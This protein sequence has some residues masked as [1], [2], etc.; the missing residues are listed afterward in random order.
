[1]KNCLIS[2]F[3]MLQIQLLTG[4]CPVFMDFHSQ[5]EIDNFASQYPN[6]TETTWNLTF[7][8]A[9]ITSLAP[10]AQLT[11]VAGGL[12]IS[13]TSLM[14]LEGLENI[15]FVENSIEII[16]NPYLTTLAALSNIAGEIGQPGGGL[17]INSNESLTSLTGLENISSID[18]GIN[19]AS[20]ASLG[21][22]TG[23]DGIAFVTDNLYI[24]GNSSLLNLGGLGALTSVY[25]IYIQGNSAM[26][27]MNGIGIVTAIPGSLTIY[28]NPNL[29]DLNDLTSLASVGNNLNLNGNTSLSSLGGLSSLSQ[30]GG[31]LNI[32][33]SALT[34]LSGLEELTSVGGGISISGNDTLT[35]ISGLSGLSNVGDVINIS[36]NPQLSECKTADLCQF[37]VAFWSNACGCSSF[38]EVCGGGGAQLI[39]F[40]IVEQE[41]N[42]FLLQDTINL[43]EPPGQDNSYGVLGRVATDGNINIIDISGYFVASGLR[44]AGDPGDVDLNGYLYKYSDQNNWEQYYYF[45]PRIFSNSGTTETVTLEV[46]DY[47]CPDKVY[48]TFEIEKHRTPVLLI[49]GLYSEG[50]IWEP[51][52]LQLMN[53]GYPEKWLGNLDFPNDQSFANA[54]PSVQAGIQYLLDEAR[55][56]GVGV[57]QVDVVGHSMGGI[58]ARYHLQSED[59]KNNI[60]KL[61]TLNTPHSGSQWANFLYDGMYDSFGSWVL[62]NYIPGS[63]ALADLRV[64][65]LA[66]QTMNMPPALNKSI[67]PTHAISTIHTGGFGALLPDVDNPL[68]YMSVLLR[69]AIG[70]AHFLAPQ[71]NQYLDYLFDGEPS[72]LIV[73]SSSQIGGAGSFSEYQAASGMEHF[74]SHANSTMQAQILNLLQASEAG[75]QFTYTGFNPPELDPP[76]LWDGTG[77]QSRGIPE[78][79]ILSP[80]SGDTLYAGLN[81]AISIAGNEE[82]AGLLA[83]YLYDDG[84]F[85]VDS[86]F[87]SSHVFSVPIPENYEG[88]I[89]IGVIGTDGYGQVDFDNLDLYHTQTTSVGAVALDDRI[90]VFPNPAREWVMISAPGIELLEVSLTDLTGRVLFAQERAAMEPLYVGNLLPGVY[91]LHIAAGS[92]RLVERIIIQR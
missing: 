7:D 64:N 69:Q 15:G 57:N 17:L 44:I 61:I 79:A 88:N 89:R 42:E 35:D 82:V 66:I 31:D 55:A 27:S 87:S 47:A 38:P 5:S 21:S 56:E 26:S 91:F 83:I 30:I 8:G 3:L 80:D 6:C 46:Y 34:N 85:I 28:D 11:K 70:F 37:P 20:N 58:L 68:V 24:A 78:I 75:S 29:A 32:G 14:T 1:M 45:S 90:N 23:L 72:D 59:Y 52:K 36:G 71:G 49:H 16:S 33:A 92:G 13:N 12:K 65:S 54:Y 67:A 81:P 43:L 4:Q 53:A 10:L 60:N 50:S 40:Y 74:Y 73:A 51:L 39:R 62:Y 77:G 25:S 48:S 86:V 63:D 19:I 76:G 41:D 84:S 9:S 2:L 22:L 18:G